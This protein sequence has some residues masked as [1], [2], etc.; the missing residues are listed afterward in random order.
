MR[1]TVDSYLE[2]LLSGDGS[3]REAWQILSDSLQR[4]IRPERLSPLLSDSPGHGTL[5]IGRNEERG[6]A[7]AVLLSGGR[8]RTIWLSTDSVGFRVS[9]DSGLDGIL[10]AGAMDCLDYAQSVVLPAL[11]SEGLASASELSC[12]SSGLRYRVDPEAGS[13]VCDA[14]HLG[15]GLEISGNRCAGRRDSV[16]SVLEAYLR[17]GYP[18]PARIADIWRLSDGAY[19]QRGG[20]RC[21]DN[22]Y[23]YYELVDGGS[24]HCPY[25]GESSTSPLLDSM[26]GS[27]VVAAPDETGHDGSGR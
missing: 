5:R 4:L 6:R 25:H 16:V 10:A 8:T 22:G 9:G 17:D 7:I 23:S 24:V 11:L 21:P 15:A 13:L 2:A 3:T 20:Y 19:G 12:P 18:Q 27:S 14:G 1:R 26:L